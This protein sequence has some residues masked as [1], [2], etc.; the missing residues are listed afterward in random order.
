MEQKELNEWLISLSGVEIGIE[1]ENMKKLMERKS[2][3]KWIWSEKFEEKLGWIYKFTNREKIVFNLL[4]SEGENFVER[5]RQKFFVRKNRPKPKN[6]LDYNE[7]EF[8]N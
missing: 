4:S 6:F 7:L 3:K 1:E 5:Q 8:L 2:R